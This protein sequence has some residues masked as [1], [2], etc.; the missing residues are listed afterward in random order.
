MHRNVALEMVGSGGFSG[1]VVLH[2]LAQDEAVFL[3]I[4]DR[5]A[6]SAPAVSAM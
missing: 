1:P 5:L 2:R 3:R 4:L 6:G